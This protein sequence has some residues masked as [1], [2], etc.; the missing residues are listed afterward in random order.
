MPEL[1]EV[2]TTVNG[3]NKTVVGKKITDVWTDIAVAKPSLPHFNE[4]TKSNAFFTLFKKAVI[5]KKFLRVERRAK[6]IL[7]HLNGGNTILIHMKMTGHLLYGKYIFDKKIKTWIPDPVEKNDALRDPFNNYIHTVFTLSNRHHLVLSDLRKFAK[8]TYFPTKNIQQT[9]LTNL[10]P[11]P[12]NRSL[13]F[14]IF[15]TQ[16]YKRNA[17]PIKKV[18]MDQECIAGIGN[19]YSDEMLW[20]A[21]IH[22]LRRIKDISLK[23]MKLLYTAM[24]KVLKK[25]IDLG[26][27]ST[28]DYRDIFG[29]PGKFQGKHEAYRRT[30]EQCRKRNCAGIIKRIVFIGRGAHFCPVHQQ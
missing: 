12:L 9:V 11:E 16:L 25:G 24:K 17:S 13:T 28:S 20:I 2:Q 8:I 6:N 15:T 14:S 4:S 19:I 1:P 3:L 30:G 27:D 21:G 29:R 18:L 5:G 26:G 23:E 7:L 10:G 22:P